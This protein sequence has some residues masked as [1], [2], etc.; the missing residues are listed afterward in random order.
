MVPRNENLKIWFNRNVL[1]GSMQWP[2]D[3]FFDIDGVAD[4][5]MQVPRGDDWPVIAKVREGHRS[6]PDSAKIEF[7][8]RRGAGRSATMDP[9]GGGDVFFH[10][11]RSVTEEY[12]FR[13][14]T[15][16]I[17]GEWVRIEL[18]ERPTIDEIALEQS[19]PEYTG[20]GKSPLEIG[21]G[22]YHILRGSQLSIKG[23]SSKPLSKAALQVGDSRIDLAIDGQDFSG[24]VPAERLAAGTYFLDIEDLERIVVP[25]PDLTASPKGLTPREPAQFKIRLRDDRAPEVELALRGVS[26]MI[27]P[28]ARLPFTAG[29]EDDYSVTDVQIGYEIRAD[30]SA[31]DDIIAGDL[32]PAGIAAR[33]GERRIDIED[34]IELE[35]LEVP[36]DS[37]LSITM[38][39]TDNDTVS[40]DGRRQGARRRSTCGSSANPSCARICYAARRSSARSSQAS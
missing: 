26:T 27:V 38:R 25:D 22:P 18:V 19:P 24:I 30:R 21:S 13:V 36:V 37:R 32:V 3:Y 1:L 23:R 40:E 2:Q 35:P 33:L 14:V 17:S 7:R 6:L 8:S 29:V 34:Y 4:G 10:T 11:L 16:K 5:V 12:D 15:K 20:E 28:R 9:G 39:A 31:A